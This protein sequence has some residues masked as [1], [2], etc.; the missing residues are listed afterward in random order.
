M[1]NFEFQNPTK[2]V[3][4]KHQISELA[5]L[6][7]KNTKILM[8]YGFGSIKKN[9][10]YDQVKGALNGF[11]VVEFAGIEANPRFETLMEAVAVVKREKID[12]ILAVGG[13]SVIDGTKFIAAAAKYNGADAWDLVAKRLPITD[14]IPFGTVLTLPATGSEMNCGAVVTHAAK[15][16]KQSFRSAVLYPQFSILDPT[17]TYSLPKRQIANGVIDSF[18]HV[19]EQYLTYPVGGHVQ[20]RF[21]ESLLQTLIE[22][23]PKTVESPKEY[24][25][26]ANL[27]WTSTLALNGLIGAG[28]VSDWTTHMIGHELTAKHGLDHAVTLAIVLPSVMEHQRQ[29]K[30]DK[31]TQY[32]KRV[33]HLVSDDQQA[34]ITQAI[35]NTR[36]FFES[37]GVKTRLSDY[38]IGEADLPKMVDHIESIGLLPLGERHDVDKNAVYEILRLSL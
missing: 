38:G 30:Q 35:A 9:G 15:K 31:L 5:N 34:L 6:I 27:V 36:S 1:L 37:L 13:G 3:F 29:Q 2:I 20:D 18:T 21:A 19:M 7:P 24:E 4:G 14:A 33:W 32:A 28:V 16:A 23:G 26:R 25:P 22:Q 8:T 10:V 12:F 17:V 11:E